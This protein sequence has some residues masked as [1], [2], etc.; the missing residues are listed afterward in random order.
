MQL[1]GEF[2]PMTEE[3]LNSIIVEKNKLPEKLFV[4]NFLPVFSGEVLIEKV[5]D[6]I[7]IWVSVAGSP[8]AAVDI[9][10]EKG[11]VLFTVPA[12]FDTNFIDPR[13]R[14]GKMDFSEIV[15][16]AKL[17]GN[18]SPA[19]EQNV[20]LGEVSKKINDMAK[21]SPKYKE[22]LDLWTNIFNRYNV[23]GNVAKKLIGVD[24]KKIGVVTDDDFE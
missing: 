8:T 21:T 17:H 11:T 6:F 1:S 23:G 24:V 14:A 22:N 15:R 12:I 7:P 2:G 10:D 18:I 5:P 4:T 19:Q 16:F 13:H 20:F 9:V 3:L